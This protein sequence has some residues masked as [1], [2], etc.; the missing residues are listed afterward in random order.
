ML[1]VGS[2]CSSVGVARTGRA[3]VSVALTDDER[4]ELVRLARARHGARSAVLRGEIILSAADDVPTVDSR[5][6]ETIDEYGRQ[7]AQPVRRA[8]I[9]GIER[10]CSIR[11][12]QAD[13]RRRDRS[14]RGGVP[15]MRNRLA[16]LTT[17]S[18]ATCRARRRGTGN[19]VPN[20][21]GGRAQTPPPGHVRIHDTRP[22]RTAP[23]ARPGLLMCAGV[24]RGS[25]NQCR[26]QLQRVIGS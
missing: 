4:V 24:P 8:S 16:G 2:A 5:Q 18:V 6:V 3:R 13:R 21:V 10:C 14:H 19:R 11:H 17:G 23:A 20:S 25:T 9:G 22:G 7:V 1:I 15:P 12:A 26:I